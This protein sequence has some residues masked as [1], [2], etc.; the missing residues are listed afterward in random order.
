MVRLQSNINKY[1]KNMKQ[2]CVLFFTITTI[3]R[4]SQEPD[5][6]TV[7]LLRISWLISNKCPESRS[8]PK[9][10]DG[11][12]MA[13][14]AGFSVQPAIDVGAV[15]LRLLGKYS[16]SKY[17]YDVT[18][19]LAT[20]DRP[21]GEL[22]DRWLRSAEFKVLVYWREMNGDMDRAMADGI[23]RSRIF[24]PLLSPTY[25][26]SRDC[27]F[28]MSLAHSKLKRVL[29][30]K[31]PGKLGSL[32]GSYMG[33]LHYVVASDRVAR[34]H[35]G[36]AGSCVWEGQEVEVQPAMTRSKGIL[37]LEFQKRYHSNVS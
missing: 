7:G 33:R 19:S 30:V 15:G 2:G 14:P 36:D 5:S 37:G 8:C 18:L 12:S 24:L 29:L 6:T 32:L 4:N 34:E 23:D 31:L 11:P 20:V 28:E 16:G 21:I 13:R 22:I 17:Q 3:C 10:E 26:S 25:E 9:K 27:M 35:G 1:S